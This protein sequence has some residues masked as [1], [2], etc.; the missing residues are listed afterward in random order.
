[1]DECSKG[2]AAHKALQREKEQLMVNIQRLTDVRSKKET[3]ECS[4]RQSP[5]QF[6]THAASVK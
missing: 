3:T 4:H 5:W 1:V 2:V 6:R